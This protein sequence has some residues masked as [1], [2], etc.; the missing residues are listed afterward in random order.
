[1]QQRTSF[2]SLGQ[3]KREDGS[4]AVLSLHR[5]PASNKSESEHRCGELP[6]CELS[7][8]PANVRK[9][10]TVYDE[11]RI[12]TRTSMQRTH[13]QMN[14]T[15]D[16]PMIM[17]NTGVLITAQDIETESVM[18][19][20]AP[21]HSNPK[22]LRRTWLPSEHTLTRLFTLGTGLST[23]SVAPSFKD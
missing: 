2:S 9:S 14:G 13:R 21:E 22:R 17:E 10:G 15:T 19:S 8:F 18:E 6:L 11:F 1:M 20:I 16:G 5:T 12:T 3:C 23:A 4:T 7:I